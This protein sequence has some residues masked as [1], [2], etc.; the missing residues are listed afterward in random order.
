ML[1]QG[2]FKKMI[3]ITDKIITLGYDKD[4]SL[5]RCHNVT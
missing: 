5:G 2:F 3:Y 1:L 4:N